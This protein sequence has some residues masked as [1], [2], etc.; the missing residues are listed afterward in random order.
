MR[1]R[2]LEPW[3][4]QVPKDLVVQGLGNSNFV[5]VKQE[6]SEGFGGHESHGPSCVFKRPF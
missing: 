6:A 4:Q 1:G 3:R 5:S 2:A